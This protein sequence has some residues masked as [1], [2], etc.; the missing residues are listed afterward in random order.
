MISW[1]LSLLLSFGIICGTPNSNQTNT[2]SS[3][4]VNY[5]TDSTIDK[6]ADI[7]ADREKSIIVGDLVI[8]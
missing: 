8:K 3:N 5:A 4:S 1:L 6:D 7:A 2:N